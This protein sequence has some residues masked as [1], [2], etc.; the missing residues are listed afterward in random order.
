MENTLYNIGL[1]N[2]NIGLEF[3]T[4]KQ[5]TTKYFDCIVDFSFLKRIYDFANVSDLENFHSTFTF[6]L[7]KREN[8]CNVGARNYMRYY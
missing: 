5:K 2:F 8:N 7:Q 1:G 6:T 4:K 3:S